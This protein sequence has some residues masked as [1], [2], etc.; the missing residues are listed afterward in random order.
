MA[1]ECM[2]STKDA[3]EKSDV[4]SYGVVLWEVFTLGETPYGTE[5]IPDLRGRLENNVRLPKPELC[6]EVL[7]DWMT[8]CWA[9]Q[10]KDRPSF[11][12]IKIGLDISNDTEDVYDYV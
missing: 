11:T 1:P 7:H 5:K 6:N 4:W 8:K 9:F 3:D 2:M 10:A 12:D